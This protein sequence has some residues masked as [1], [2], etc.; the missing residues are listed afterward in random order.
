MIHMTKFV[1]G[2]MFVVI[3][4]LPVFIKKTNLAICKDNA[5]LFFVFSANCQTTSQA[6]VFIPPD[7]S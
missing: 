2:N 1:H 5:L 7:Y 3:V 4:I 6:R